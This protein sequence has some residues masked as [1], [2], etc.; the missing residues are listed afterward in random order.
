[1]FKHVDFDDDS[2]VEVEEDTDGV[3]NQEGTLAVVTIMLP[4]KQRF[5]NKF[6]DNS[7]SGNFYKINDSLNFILNYFRQN[8]NWQPTCTCTCVCFAKPK[9]IGE[10]LSFPRDSVELFPFKSIDAQLINLAH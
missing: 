9:K 5:N 2:D 10:K 7:S 4:V 6:N 1:M 8:S 3:N